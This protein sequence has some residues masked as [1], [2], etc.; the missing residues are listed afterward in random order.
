MLHGDRARLVRRFVER[1]DHHDPEFAD[2]EIPFAVYAALRR[3]RP[4]AWTDAHGGFWV[5]SRYADVARVARD[6][7]TFSSARG[8]TIPH[9][10]PPVEGLPPDQQLRMI[11]IDV[12][13]PQFFAYRKLVDPLFSPARLPHQEPDVREIV[14]RLIDAFIAKGRCDLHEDFAKPLPGIL[15]VR[16]LGLPEADW[17]RY[18][19]PFHAAIHAKPEQAAA[20]ARDF[21]LDNARAML[22]VAAERRSEPRKDVLSALASA[23]LEGRPLRDL[24]IFGIANL[25]L[26][27]GVETTTNA[28]GS[29]FVYLSRHPELRQRLIESPGLLPGAVEEF[30]RVFAPVQGLARTAMRDCEIAGQRIREGERVLMLWASANRDEAEFP[31]PD[32]V[33]VD[34]HPNRHLTFG[35]GNHR[36]LGSNLARLE[37][38]IALEELLRRIPDFRVDEAGLR[39]QPDVGTTFGYGAI[40]VRFTPG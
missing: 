20:G 38:R 40:P 16:I 3:E 37:F 10:V 18:A 1:F 2:E 24:E 30:L 9:P 6:D 15:T 12:D 29:A 26:V 25:I 39:V 27:G 7:L 11:P 8:I 5:V 28:M 31:A 35:V 36:C 17:R 32:D 13:P 22:A 34:R 19:E 23:T 4:V 14:G 33:I 21:Y